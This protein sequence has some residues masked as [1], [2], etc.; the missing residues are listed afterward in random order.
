[1]FFTEIEGRVIL[2]V[3]SAK[4]F[5]IWQSEADDPLQFQNYTFPGKNIILGK[6]I[7]QQLFLLQNNGLIKRTIISGLVHVKIIAIPLRFTFFPL[8]ILYYLKCQTTKVN[9]NK[10]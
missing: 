5:Q 10:R 1:M 3:S 9:G 2:L 7:D 4:E 6:V 8:P